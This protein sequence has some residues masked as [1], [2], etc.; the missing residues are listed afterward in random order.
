MNPSV[1]TDQSVRVLI[2]QWFFLLDAHAEAALPEALLDPDLTIQLPEITIHSLGDFATWYDHVTRV[3][4]DEVHDVLT[5]DIAISADGQT[6][7]VSL[8]VRWLAR[9]WNAPAPRSEW[10]GFEASQQWE[11]RLSPTGQPMIARY[12]VVSLT[13]LPG[14]ASL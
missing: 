2:N 3:F 4:F 9:R 8:L 10:L 6:A 13:P 12:I 1:L 5:A 11:V 14:S 7:E